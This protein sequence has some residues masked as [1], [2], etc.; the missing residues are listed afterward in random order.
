[1]TVPTVSVLM[2]VRNGAAFLA[3]AIAGVL[4]QTGP[5]FEF[6]IIDDGSTDG[7]AEILASQT[8]PRIVVRRN[9]DNLGLTASLNIGL[10]MTRGEFIARMDVDDQA[11]PGR[12][13]AQVEALTRSGASICF[14]RCL[15]I[16][17]VTGGE[18][19]RRELERPLLR[20]RV[21]FD[22]AFGAHPAAMFRRQ[23][24]IEAGGYDEGFRY[25]QDYDLWDRC[26]ARGLEFIYV[27]RPLLRF[28]AHRQSITVLRAEEQAEAARAVSLRALRR[29]FND[30][31]ED[32]LAGLRWLMM[33]GA[34]PRQPEAVDAALHGCLQRAGQFAAP[35]V[36]KDVA[37]RLAR[38]LKNLDGARRG[39]A[40]RRMLGAAV[41]SRSAL[42]LA[43]SVYAMFF[44]GRV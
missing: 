7:T 23:A 26:L 39:S 44:S 35:S 11:L 10:K 24:V 3:D 42:T 4:A 34:P 41:R 28:C 25:A 5:S 27:P 15:I 17:K 21:L 13:E 33:G 2:A 30:A 8:D 20:W 43:R 1:M 9:A 36:W 37:A 32:E 12:L 6:V 29:A 16:D 40:A 22:N 14:C 18:K 38:R 19:E 31:S